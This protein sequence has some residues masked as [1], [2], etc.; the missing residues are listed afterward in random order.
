MA[1]RGIGVLAVHEITSKFRET[2]IMPDDQQG[3]YGSGCSFNK[4][5]QDINIGSVEQIFDFAGRFLRKFLQHAIE[6]VA[7]TPG[8]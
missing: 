8:R 3:V 5:A 4:A 6:R 1:E 7:R 2:R